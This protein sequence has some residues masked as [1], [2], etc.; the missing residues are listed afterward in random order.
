MLLYF[1]INILQGDYEAFHT[2]DIDG[3]IQTSFARISRHD[4]TCCFIGPTF[5]RLSTLGMMHSR[6]SCKVGGWCQEPTK[7][8]C[9]CECVPAKTTQ[10]IHTTSLRTG[11]TYMGSILDILGQEPFSILG[12]I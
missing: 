3:I 1:V 2:A 10:G 9:E 7:Q 5:Q 11:V 12:M 8:S 4:M 6:G